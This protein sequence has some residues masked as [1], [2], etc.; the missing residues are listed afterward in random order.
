MAKKELAS[1]YN[2]AEVEK[3]KYQLWMDKKYFKANPNSNKKPFSIILPP[4]NVTG[5]L[6]IGHA[7]GVSIQ[8]ALIRYKKFKGFDTVFI[9]GMDHAG[10]STQ[11]K[12]EA[13]LKELGISRFDISKEEFL[14]HVWDWKEEYAL[15]IRNQWS[16]MGLGF[17]YDL[18][19]FTLDADVNAKVQEIFVEF[20]NKK[21]IYKGK[22]IVNWDPI[23]K[24]AVS[25]IEVIYK[26]VEGEMFYFKYFLESKDNFLSVATTRPE[27]MFADQCIVVNPSDQR[28]AKFIGKNV[29][30]PVNKEIIPIIAD[31]YVE[32]EFGTGVMK[33]TPAHDLNDFEIGERHNLA[34]PICMNEDATINQMGGELYA[35]LDRFTA[36]KK[37][38]KQTK[39]DNTFIKS[40]KIVHQVGYSERSNAI[41]EPY[42][43]DQ[44]FVD[45]KPFQQMILEMQQNDPEIVFYPKRFNDVLIKWM[46]NVHD[47]TISRQLWWGHQIPAWYHIDDKSKIY[48]GTKPPIDIENWVQ[49]Q[50]VL[51]TW[52]SSGLW[53]FVTTMRSENEQSV[54][55]KKYFPI[56]VMVTGFDIIFFWVARMIF[57]TKEYTNKIP[58]KDVLIHGLVRAEDGAK[59]SKS[60]GNGVDPMQI[61]EEKGA[62]ALR[63]FLLNGSTPGLDFKFSEIKITSAWNFINKLW[64]ASRYVMINIDDSFVLNKNFYNQ[65]KLS[66]ADKW[67]L[68][69]LSIVEK[70]VSE[71]MDKYEF[72]LVGKILYDFVWNTYCSWYIEL[73]K[74]NLNDSIKKAASK[75][76]L[77]YVLK[78]ILVM[79]HPFIPFVTEHIYQNLNMKDSI[80]EESWLKINHCYETDYLNIV[81]DLIGSIREFKAINNLNNKTHLVFQINNLTFDKNKIINK[82]LNQINEFLLSFVNSKI[83]L[84]INDDNKKTIIPIQDFTIEIN[85]DEFIDNEKMLKEMIIQKQSLEQELLRSEKMLN[86]INFIAKANPDKIVEEKA[87]YEQYK[88]QLELINNKLNKI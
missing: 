60:A 13:K 57:Q 72:A 39:K 30:N 59:M 40:E 78:N 16:K 19:K 83:I 61:I 42:L 44:W 63:F 35:G 77:V 62:D 79:L 87:K 58:F 6:H 88:I 45:M 20:Y 46:E 7:F 81:V 8:D 31:E 80:L 17:D 73:S 50:D 1:K 56:S 18:E 70:S 3:N 67:I 37:I 34:K 71:L 24:T 14:K 9:P 5:K 85:N 15:T 75:Q 74:V 25:N 27:T 23:Q 76:T 64:N 54:Y 51:D 41:I 38:I 48:V 29:I 12:V 69:Q 53:P 11:V 52:F 2:N 21:L 68:T 55:F 49:D 65:L 33:C 4:P 86:N 82:N 28:Y 84:D 22:R 10:I 32:I 47:W 66:D 26:E 43:S 36:R